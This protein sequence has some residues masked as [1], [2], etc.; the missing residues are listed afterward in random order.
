MIN[1]AVSPNVIVDVCPNGTH[2]SL[3]KCYKG[4]NFVYLR[5]EERYYKGD[6]PDILNAGI[7]TFMDNIRFPVNE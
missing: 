4:S 5:K 1:K 2:Q 6:N 7:N 3:D